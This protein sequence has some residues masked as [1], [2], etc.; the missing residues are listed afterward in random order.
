VSRERAHVLATQGARP[1]ARLQERFRAELE[2]VRG[3]FGSEGASN[4]DAEDGAQEVLELAWRIGVFAGEPSD[5]RDFLTQATQGKLR[6]RRRPA[7]E[8]PAGLLRRGRRTPDPLTA[9]VTQ[10]AR[11]LVHASLGKLKRVHRAAVLLHDIEGLSASEAAQ[12]MAVPLFTFYSRLRNGRLRLAARLR[13]VETVQRPGVFTEP[14][15]PV[16]GG[17]Q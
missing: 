16:D 14:V 6:Q 12:A 15:D 10:Q 9:F 13:R 2:H 11:G 7:R 5:V 3:L 8:A 4:A 17:D 1:D